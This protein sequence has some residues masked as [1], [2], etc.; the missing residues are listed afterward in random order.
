MENDYSNGL[1]VQYLGING[2][3]TLPKK[4]RSKLT[5]DLYPASYLSLWKG[6]KLVAVPDIN[7]LIRDIRSIKKYDLIDIH[8]HLMEG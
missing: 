4:Y 7:Y 3:M 8:P 5:K 6:K 2:L 1:T